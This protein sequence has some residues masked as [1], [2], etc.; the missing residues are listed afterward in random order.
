MKR[1]SQLKIWYG[2][3]IKSEVTLT[4]FCFLLFLISAEEMDKTV[5][6]LTE[7]ITRAVEEE[8]KREA[9]KKAPPRP[10]TV[11]KAY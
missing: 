5:D 8:E 2:Q 1:E 6:R 7:T 11:G 10:Q 4:F 9:E 3:A